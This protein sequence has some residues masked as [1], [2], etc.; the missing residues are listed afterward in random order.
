LST[1]FQRLTAA[2]AKRPVGELVL[3]IFKKFRCEISRFLVHEFG[4]GIRNRMLEGEGA[5]NLVDDSLHGELLI[6]VETSL[7]VESS[8]RES[9][10]RANRFNAA[11]FTL[12]RTWDGILPPMAG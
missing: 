3:V 10:G 5:H 7:D 9:S 1:A 11:L 12:E 6:P 2:G 8:N 4:L